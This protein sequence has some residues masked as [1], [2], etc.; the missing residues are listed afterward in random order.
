MYFQNFVGAGCRCCVVRLFAFCVFVSCFFYGEGLVLLPCWFLVIVPSSLSSKLLCAF[1]TSHSSSV[2]S[3]R[4]FSRSLRGR[5]VEVDLV[6][7]WVEV[8]SSTTLD[9]TVVQ[10]VALKP[11]WWCLWWLIMWLALV[12]LCSSWID[13]CYCSTVSVFELSIWFMVGRVFG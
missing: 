6:P 11:W 4:R 7:R 8:F 10:R 1:P 2:F 5:S 13:L 3:W 9:G 12:C